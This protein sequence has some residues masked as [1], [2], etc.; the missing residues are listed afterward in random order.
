MTPDS[1]QYHEFNLDP[2]SMRRRMLAPTPPDWTR[3]Q[4]EIEGYCEFER[5]LNT[6]LT[7]NLH[8]RWTL[9]SSTTL[10][11]ILVVIGF[12]MVNDAVMFR[13][14]DGHTAWRENEVVQFI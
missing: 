5:P 4:F 1:V 7:N 3:H 6:W 11:G 12:E 14:M 2:R 8:G 10:N 13:L 9:N